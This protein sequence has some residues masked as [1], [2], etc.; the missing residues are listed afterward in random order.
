[1]MLLSYRKRVY[2]WVESAFLFALGL[3]L[4]LLTLWTVTINLDIPEKAET[5]LLVVLTVLAVLRLTLFFCEESSSWKYW[6]KVLLLALLVS[7]V[8]LLVYLNDGYVFLRFLAVLTPGCIGMDYRKVVKL[9]VFVVGLTVLSAVVCAC[10]GAIQNR[11]YF[12][13]NHLRSA[14]GIGYPTDFSSYLVFLCV[15]AWIAWRKVPDWVF[16]GPGMISLLVAYYITRSSTSVFCSILFLLLVLFH[17]VLQKYSVPKLMQVVD[18]LSSLSFPLFGAGMIGLTWLYHQRNALATR[19]DTWNHGRLLLASKAYDAYGLKL[20]GSPLTQVGFGGS[21]VPPPGYNFVDCSYLLILLRYGLVAFLTIMALWC[22][23]S[24]KA[25]KMQDRRLLLGMALIAFHSLSEHHFTEINYNILL[26]LLF[27]VLYGGRLSC[28]NS[29]AVSESTEV[30]DLTAR[31]RAVGLTAAAAAL[32]LLALPW[33]MSCFRTCCSLLKMGA[34]VSH[35]RALFLAVFVGLVFLLFM[36]RVVYVVLFAFIRKERPEKKQLLSV[37]A[38]AFCILLGLAG[39]HSVFRKAADQAYP[40]M[41]SDRKAIEALQADKDCRIFVADIPELYQRF[42]GGIER[43]AFP[44]EDLARFHRVAVL[45]DVNLDSRAFIGRGFLFAE[46]SDTHAVY[47]NS[48]VAAQ[49]LKDAGFHVTG[50]Y[51]NE[52]SVNLAALAALNQIPTP[53]DGSLLVSTE[54]PLRDGPYLE[55]FGSPYKVSFDLSLQSPDSDM[56]LPQLVG[57]TPVCKLQVNSRWGENRIKEQIL[58]FDQFDEEEILT[59][60]VTCTIPDTAGVEFLVIPEVEDVE[61]VLHGIHYQKTP[62]YDVHAVYDDNWHRVREL[63]YDLEGTPTINSSGYHA[64]DFGYDI[65]GNVNF[66][67]YYDLDGNSVVNTDGFAEIHRMFDKDKRLLREEYFDTDGNPVALTRNQAGVEYGYDIYGN[68]VL[69]R[70]L[71]K[72]GEPVML[73]DGYAELRQIY[74]DKN[75]VIRKSYFDEYG[76]LVVLPAGQASTVL[77]YDAAGNLSSEAYYDKM[78]QPVNNI[79]GYAREERRYDNNRN[80]IGIK[81]YGTDG[82]PICIYTGYAEVRRVYDNAKRLIREAYFDESGAPVQRAS[83]YCGFEQDYDADGKLL[84]RRYLGADGLPIQRTDGISEARWEK[85]KDTALRNLMLYSLDGNAVP[86]DGINLAKDL[87]SDGWSR[88]MLPQYD[89]INS[90]FN[91]GTVNL[92]EKAEGDAYTCQIEIEFSNVTATEGKEFHFWTQGAADGF[93]SIGNVWNSNLVSVNEPPANGIYSFA[94]TSLVN[95]KMA[96]A[97]TFSLG[98]RCDNWASGAFRVRDV[99][100]ERGDAATPWSPGL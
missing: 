93:W 66:E 71:G 90:C 41:E 80:L 70:Y 47:T 51:S 89:S 67:R 58:T 60:D 19:I 21:V 23:A 33:L 2:C 24:L 17:M 55:L 7:V 54:H 74:N 98:F 75:Q 18:I 8:W 46:I 22:L 56:P 99:K 76:H 3:Y 96:D 31:N 15:N 13:D 34:G 44:T 25:S 82:N 39:M 40:V 52:M 77:S 26:I 49:R 72:D 57:D 43:T 38:C 78:G 92:S 63:Y 35:Q 27:A 79:N 10:G 42:Y 73:A 69:L 50:Y 88:W 61:V 12:S 84:S 65:D 20:F 37:I 16:L 97:S 86:L 94:V 6:L 48:D 81:Y 87:E 45:T 29:K 85:S 59:A 11:I 1:M 28:E 95:D 68:R 53:G 83:G 64:R 36:F 30:S 9:Q 32:L 100:V 14:W 5:D 62:A 91:I 4:L